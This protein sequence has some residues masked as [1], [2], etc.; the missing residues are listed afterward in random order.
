MQAPCEIIGKKVLP[1]I[2]GIIVRYMYEELGL[3]QIQIARLLGV[4]QS[5]IS[6]YINQQRG[7]WTAM[8]A[9]KDLEEKIQEVTKLLID[10]KINREEILCEI[11]RYI[12]ATHP[13]VLAES[14]RIF[15][16]NL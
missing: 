11:C 15:H 7:K 1:S 10:K 2:R 3:T 13:E 16:G 9:S 14:S 12:R 6:R 8:S 4:S 5:S